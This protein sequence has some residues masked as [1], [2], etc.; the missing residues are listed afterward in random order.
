MTGTFE[1]ATA[2]TA[3]NSALTLTPDRYNNYRILITGGTGA[4]Q[5][6]RITCH[7]ATQF[8]IAKDW[9]ITPD[10]TSTYEIW[11]DFDRIYMAIGARSTILAYSPENDFWMQGQ[12]IDDGI[13]A[14]LS[15]KK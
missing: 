3:T 4:G 14:I 11:S 15:A 8:W 13:C 1:S 10:A 5:N 2:R 7:T 9:D 12:S 6:R